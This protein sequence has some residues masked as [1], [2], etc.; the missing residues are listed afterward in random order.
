MGLGDSTAY[1]ALEI[2]GIRRLPCAWVKLFETAPKIRPNEFK[3]NLELEV[4]RMSGV[5]VYIYHVLPVNCNPAKKANNG[6]ENAVSIISSIC[7]NKR[8]AYD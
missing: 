2:K 3:V 4:S 1:H 8:L 5:Q 7:M 6:K